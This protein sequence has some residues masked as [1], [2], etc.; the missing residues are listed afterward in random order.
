MNSLKYIAEQTKLSSY[1]LSVSGTDTRNHVL[2]HVSQLLTERTV[3]IV[4]ANQIDY[5]NGKTSGLNDQMLDRLLLT[6]ERIEGIASDVQ[7]IKNL[8]D[9]VGEIIEQ[10]TLE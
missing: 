1:E 9:P 4:A 8:D 7:T 5:Q 6:P 2:D 3:D 10:K